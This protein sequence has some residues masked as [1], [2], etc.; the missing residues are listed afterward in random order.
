MGRFV[1]RVEVDYAKLKTAPVVK[2][3]KTLLKAGVDSIPEALN[4][5]SIWAAALG[6][7]YK[8]PPVPQLARAKAHTIPGATFCLRKPSKPSVGGEG[9]L[10]C[11]YVSWMVQLYCK[12]EHGTPVRP[13]ATIV[14][15]AGAEMALSIANFSSR[16]PVN[17]RSMSA[18][19][20]VTVFR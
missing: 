1:D 8:P 20:F 18:V 12:E 3:P 5:L 9:V 10:K 6:P 16:V 19:C 11:L 4:P 13:Q 17:C 14:E 7:K 2:L 15:N